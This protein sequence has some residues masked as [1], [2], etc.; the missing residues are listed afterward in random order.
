MKK[1]DTAPDAGDTGIHI[2]VFLAEPAV[3]LCPYSFSF[4]LEHLMGE[5]G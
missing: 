5:Y 2:P 1:T 3:R 4:R